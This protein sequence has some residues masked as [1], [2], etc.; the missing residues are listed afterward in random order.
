MISWIEPK[1]F[2]T[3][4]DGLWWTVVT[5][6]T[7]GYGDLF[8]STFLGRIF[9]ILV[10]FTGVALIGL[11][12]G[13]AGELITLHR[14]KEEEGKLGYDGKNHVVIIDWSDKAEHA[15]RDIL[16]QEKKTH[17]VVIDQLEKAPYLHERVHYV[18]GNPS[19]EVVLKSLANVEK[20]KA[21]FI[22]GDETIGDQWLKDCKTLM[23]ATAIERIAPHVFTVAEIEMDENAPN[24]HHLKVDKLIF[25]D[26]TISSLAIQ[27]YQN[28]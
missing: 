9:G 15:I 10:I 13:K 3:F 18:N 22:F 11:V 5:A 28:K 6:A 27:A 24:F 7:V 1:T 4:F 19:N 17:V 23:I 25:T 12:F 20:A 8:P 21:C 2:P 26:K 14:K 16:K